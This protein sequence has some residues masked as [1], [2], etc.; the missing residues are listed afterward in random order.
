MIRFGHCCLHPTLGQSPVADFTALGTAD[1]TDLADRIGRKVVV[2]QEWLAVFAL[3]GVN[4]LSVPIS[5][6]RRHYQRLGLSL[7]HI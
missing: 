3:K 4:A 1:L 5:A 6:Q 2:Q 7:I